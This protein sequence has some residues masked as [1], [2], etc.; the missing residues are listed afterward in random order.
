MGK[1]PSGELIHLLA[2]EDPCSFVSYLHIIENADRD[3]WEFRIGNWNCVNTQEPLYWFLWTHQMT[4]HTE[5]VFGKDTRHSK[6]LCE[7]M[8]R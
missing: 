3:L 8:E 1:S 5:K 2:K 6:G 4:Q 7:G